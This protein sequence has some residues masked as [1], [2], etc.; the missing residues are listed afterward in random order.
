M[1]QS[2]FPPPL[3]RYKDQVAFIYKDFPL[4]E[5]HPWAMRASVDANCLPPKARC[6]LGL[7]GL[8]PLHGDEVS[9]RTAIRQELLPSSTALPVSRALW[10]SSTPQARRLLQSRTDRSERFAQRSHVLDWKA[11]RLCSSMASASMAPSPRSS[12]GWHRP[13]LRAAGE[14]PQPR[15]RS[16]P[17]PNPVLE[18]RCAPAIAEPARGYILECR[19]LLGPHRRD[20]VASSIEHT[21]HSHSVVLILSPPPC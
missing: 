10:A 14:Q 11:L 20:K 7:R 5:N 18:I 16:P 13:S 8:P 12:S 3:A 19:G 17:P 2:L 6:L 1:H 9:A 4:L 15:P 21:M